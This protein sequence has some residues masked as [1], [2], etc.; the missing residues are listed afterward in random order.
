MDNGK[1]VPEEQFKDCS[2]DGELANTISESRSDPLTR[3]SAPLPSP[4]SARLGDAAGGKIEAP[5]DG[6]G[7]KA[8]K[9]K[10]SSAQHDA[11]ILRTY[12]AHSLRC[13]RIKFGLCTCTEDKPF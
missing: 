10:K 9:P 2:D 5:P 7:K 1:V 3:R 8:K 6:R 11:C 4:L 13:G 12:T